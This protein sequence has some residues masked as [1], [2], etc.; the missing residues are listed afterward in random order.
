MRVPPSI[1]VKYEFRSVVG[2]QNSARL[3]RK[4]NIGNVPAKLRATYGKT[5]AK[6]ENQTRVFLPE[7]QIRHPEGPTN[8]II[9]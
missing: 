1:D 2:K 9:L 3:A 5:I 8:E 4:K 7:K 6:P